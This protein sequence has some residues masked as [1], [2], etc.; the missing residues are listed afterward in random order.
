[1][2]KNTVLKTMFVVLGVSVSMPGCG[3]Q[4]THSTAS[5]AK[6][7]MAQNEVVVA[8]T[9]ITQATAPAESSGQAAELKQE[10]T[11]LISAPVDI[12]LK[13]K[14]VQLALRNANFYSGEIDGKIGPKTKEAIKKFQL[15]KDLTA[16]GVVGSRTWMELKAYLP[17]EQSSRGK[18]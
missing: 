4:G 15:S 8:S 12:T 9:P 10:G 3:W 13:N 2:D 14:A 6:P 18:P 1:M 7:V 11:A 5:Q 16:D 17:E